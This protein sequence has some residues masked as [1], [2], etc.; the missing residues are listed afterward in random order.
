MVL[1]SSDA[2]DSGVVGAVDGDRSAVDDFERDGYVI[3]EDALP[4]DLVHDLRTEY[5]SLLHAKQR[6]LGIERV[7][8]DRGSEDR[9]GRPNF[10]PLGG[11]HD[12]NRW[13]MHLPSRLPFLDPRVFA[14][15]LAMNVID[16]IMGDE[17]V[18][19]MMASDAASP[20]SQLQEIHQD[21][22]VTR[23]VVNIPLVDC[24]LR[25]GAIELWPGTHRQSAPDPKGRFDYDGPPLSQER[26]RELVA[27]VPSKRGV[28]KAG[29]IL[30][31]DQRLLHRGTRNE[32]EEVRPMLS[33][34][35]FADAVEVPY[36]LGTNVAARAALRLRE[37]ARRLPTG[38]RQ[39]TALSRGNAA[40]RI[41]EFMARSDRDYRRP[42]PHDVWRNLP[43]RA[44]RLLRHASVAGA[45]GDAA[46][47]AG[48]A[49]LRA[50]YTMLR[51]AANGMSA[52]VGGC[53]GP[54]PRGKR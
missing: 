50:T 22:Y 10:I 8:L 37:V 38:K 53:K 44:R 5:L 40:G 4:A 32:T 46:K 9:Y 49:S 2:R 48:R 54:A 15:P 13:N 51:A 52:A 16:A 27:A 35:Y 1:L 31:R 25:N 41:V 29:S 26:I 43:E 28:M 17:C 18:L 47:V 6:R 14:N 11:N 33:F 21:S 34:L 3:F 42:I 30:L 24:D 23:L 12:V 19:T 36:R 45:G 20:G 39:A 7:D